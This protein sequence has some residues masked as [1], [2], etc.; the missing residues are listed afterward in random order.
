MMT[1]SSNIKRLDKDSG[2]DTPISNRSYESCSRFHNSKADIKLKNN[3]FLFEKW[4]RVEAR[5]IVDKNDLLYDH[6]KFND[7]IE[8]LI[9]MLDRRDHFDRIFAR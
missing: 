9:K 4:I 3:D 1:I 5:L 6:T 2:I 7:A 8:I